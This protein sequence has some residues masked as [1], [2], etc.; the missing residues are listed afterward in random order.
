MRKNVY[1]TA[2]D[3]CKSTPYQNNGICSIMNKGFDCNCRGSFFGK[4]CQST[5]RVIQLI[6]VPLCYNAGD[7]VEVREHVTHNSNKT[8][9]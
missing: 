4:R 5:Y 8:V 1:D 7:I 9:Y 6:N 2:F 3:T